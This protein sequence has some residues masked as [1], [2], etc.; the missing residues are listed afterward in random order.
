MRRQITFQE[1]YRMMR[2]LGCQR[3][4]SWFYAAVWVLR[5]DQIN[6]EQRTVPT[7]NPNEIN[8]LVAK[9]D[10]FLPSGQRDGV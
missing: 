4:T 3:F 8:G 9:A 6:D 7:A 2:Q 10:V 1:G 5:G